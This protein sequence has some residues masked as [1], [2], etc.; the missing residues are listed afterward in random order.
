MFAMN[1]INKIDYCNGSALGQSYLYNENQENIDVFNIDSSD[2]DNSRYTDG[3][4]DY[5]AESNNDHID[6]NDESYDDE[7]ID[8]LND[9]DLNDELFNRKNGLLI[10]NWN[11]DGFNNYIY[12]I[13][14]YIIHTKKPDIFTLQEGYKTYDDGNNNYVF[15]IEGY[16]S[17]I[18]DNSGYGKVITLVRKNVIQEMIDITFE[19][20]DNIDKKLLDLESNHNLDTKTRTDLLKTQLYVVSVLTTDVTNDAK[21]ITINWYRTISTLKYLI[22]NKHFLCS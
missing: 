9:N 20:N 2:V 6:I 7:T 22:S 13:L 15:H 19:P 3:A 12:P 8:Q 18:M 5:Y 4:Y 10:C 21:T 1:N 11:I 17:Y 14:N 16:N